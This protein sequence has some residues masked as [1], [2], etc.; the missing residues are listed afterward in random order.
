M[1]ISQY[2]VLNYPPAWQKAT[3]WKIS[4]F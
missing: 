1:N 2:G 3:P 4:S